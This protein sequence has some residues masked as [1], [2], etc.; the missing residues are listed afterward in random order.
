MKGGCLTTVL[1]GQKRISSKKDG[2]LPLSILFGTYQS[3]MTQVK[4][5]LRSTTLPCTSVLGQ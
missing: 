2:Q 1:K 4:P 5:S 3:S